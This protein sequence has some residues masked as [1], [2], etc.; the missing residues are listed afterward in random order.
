MPISRD[1]QFVLDQLI[2]EQRLSQQELDSLKQSLDQRALSIHWEIKTLLSVGFGLFSVGI[3]KLVYDYID[4]YLHWIILSV[5]IFG[6]VAST[7]YC[8]TRQEAFSWEKVSQKKAFFDAALVLCTGLFLSLEGYLQYEFN[9]FGERY[10]EM[11]I[12]P[13]LF[14]FF[15]AYYFDNYVILTKGMIAFSAWFAIRF[16]VFNWDNPDIFSEPIPV[17]ESVLIG[18]AF[19]ATG[20]LMHWLKLKKHFKKTYLTFA[21][22]LILLALTA[23]LIREDPPELAFFILIIGFSLGFYV[24]SLVEKDHVIVFTVL[25]YFYIALTAYLE[26]LNWEDTWSQ[27][28][29]FFGTGLAA[30]MYFL[31]RRKAYAEN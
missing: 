12:V 21:T 22:Q 23:R 15:C 9:F 28:F 4:S 7:F 30:I 1:D 29:Y 27:G 24:L 11:A 14:Y 5:L 6:F 8:F 3:G 25:V 16:Q 20:Y 10:A 17:L 19:L 26:V 2:T 18:L 13:T 31:Y